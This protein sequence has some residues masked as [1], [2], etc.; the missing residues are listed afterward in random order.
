MSEMTCLK[1]EIFSVKDEIKA[2]KRKEMK[3]QE[4]KSHSLEVQLEQ[5]K[6]TRIRLESTIEEL[7]NKIFMEE[8]DR[9][10]IGQEAET[11]ESGRDMGKWWNPVNRDERETREIN[12]PQKTFF[13]YAIETYMQQTMSQLLILMQPE[14]SNELRQFIWGTQSSATQMRFWIKWL[15]FLSRK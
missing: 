11:S 9:M 6:Q 5:E 10:D 3:R 8:K 15:N 13:V 14:M 2:A 12:W 1:K 4:E 7:Q